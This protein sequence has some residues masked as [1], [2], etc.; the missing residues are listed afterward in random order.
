MNHGRRGSHGCVFEC[1]HPRGEH[2]GAQRC[3][4]HRF[5]GQ[6]RDQRHPERREPFDRA[7]L[8]QSVALACRKRGIEQVEDGRDI[9]GEMA[10]QIFGVEPGTDDFSHY[11]YIS[12]RGVFGGIFMVGPKT[13]RNTIWDLAGLWLDWSVAQKT[14]YGFRELYP[15]IEKEYVRQQDLVQQ[16]GYVE[17]VDGTKSWFGPRDHDNTAWNRKV[18]GSLALFNAHWLTQVES[19]TEQWDALVLSV[20]D[21]VTLDLPEDVAE[22]VVADIQEWTAKEFEKWFGIVGGTDAEW[23][24]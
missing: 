24:Y 11:R 10:T 17:L 20:H 13:F 21:S 18:Q 4:R 15:E 14:V 1:R 23:G 6:A 5:E 12:K 2:A 16:H 8:E 7:K 22:Q 9:H 3:Q 19:M